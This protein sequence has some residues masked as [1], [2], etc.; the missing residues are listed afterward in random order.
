MDGSDASRVAMANAKSKCDG[1]GK[2][3]GPGRFTVAAVEGKAERA[4]R[5]TSQ[6]ISSILCMISIH[7][8][9]TAAL[10]PSRINL[11]ALSC[12]PF[13]P[14]GAAPSQLAG[15]APFSANCSAVPPAMFVSRS[16]SPLLGVVGRPEPE[17]HRRQNK[18]DGS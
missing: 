3:T 4:A 2:A 14:L 16:L 6:R 9:P 10:F 13:R 7:F 17:R 12:S 5:R 1:R 18:L 11:C 15:P 8:C